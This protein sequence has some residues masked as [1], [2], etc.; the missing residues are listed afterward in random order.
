MAGCNAGLSPRHWRSGL[1]DIGGRPEPREPS[2]HGQ[3][4]W[5]YEGGPPDPQSYRPAFTEDPMSGV[6]DRVGVRRSPHPSLPR[7]RW[8]VAHGEFGVR[9]PK[10]HGKVRPR[11]SRNTR[12]PSLWLE[13]GAFS[14]PT[15]S[16]RYLDEVQP[17][18]Q[19]LGRFPRWCLCDWV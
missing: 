15:S 16:T 11:S 9:G 6:R 17:S 10:R 18:Y 7:R 1:R 2:K 19:P 13:T 12:T 8:W 4:Y 5:E 3:E 14:V